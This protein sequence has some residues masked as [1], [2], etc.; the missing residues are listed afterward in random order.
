MAISLVFERMASY[1][2]QIADRIIFMT[3]DTASEE[4]ESFLSNLSNPVIHKP[5]TINELRECLLG[6]LKGG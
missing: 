1:D 6:V 3:G 5:F 4:T 2:S